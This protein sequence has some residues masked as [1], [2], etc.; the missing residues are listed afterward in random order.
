MS[1]DL[2]FAKKAEPDMT[3]VNFNDHFCEPMGVVERR[4]IEVFP[5]L[6]NLRPY[7]KMNVEI[8]RIPR[9][10]IAYQKL[11]EETKDWGDQK[12]LPE[13][14]PEFPLIRRRFLGAKSVVHTP[15]LKASETNK[16]RMA[17]FSESMDPCFMGR[18]TAVQQHTQFAYETKSTRRRM[19]NSA[20][21]KPGR[22]RMGQV[23]PGANYHERQGRLARSRTDS[24]EREVRVGHN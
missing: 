16:K 17:K 21:P 15:R 8:T 22:G 5:K 9:L 18:N 14:I 19:S 4:Y 1:E 24:E 13:E 12:K 20:T 6:W 11:K 10:M 7:D 2:L 23:G 3:A